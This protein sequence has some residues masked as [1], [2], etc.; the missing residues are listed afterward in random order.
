MIIPNSVYAVLPSQ[1]G[2]GDSDCIPFSGEIP[3][4]KKKW[5]VLGMTQD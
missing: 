2:F 4:L 5:D 3:P 1:W